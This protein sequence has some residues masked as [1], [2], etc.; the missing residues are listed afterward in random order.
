M[1]ERSIRATGPTRTQL[2]EINRTGVSQIFDIEHREIFRTALHGC[3]NA[4]S[5]KRGI[6]PE[7][8]QA[9]FFLE[10]ASCSVGGFCS[11]RTE[12]SITFAR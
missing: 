5:W 10:E 6:L 11:A 1:F 7:L 12:H 2:R 8:F 9:R 4:L 3:R